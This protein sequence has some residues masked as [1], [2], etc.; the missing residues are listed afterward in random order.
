MSYE[1]GLDMKAGFKFWGA[2][3]SAGLSTSYASELETETK[4]DMEKSID[5]E[6]ELT[7]SG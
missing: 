1:M 4:Q 3:V 5:I 7:C 2:S 6:Y